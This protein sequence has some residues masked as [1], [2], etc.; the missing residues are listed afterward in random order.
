MK[1]PVA[2]QIQSDGVVYCYDENGNYVCGQHPHTGKAISA[3]INGSN[4]IIQTDN[5]KTIIYE[6]RNGSVSYKAT[7]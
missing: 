4:L 6:I 2:A 1:I 7:R 3:Q 5:G